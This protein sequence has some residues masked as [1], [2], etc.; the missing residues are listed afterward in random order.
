VGII[1]TGFEAIFNYAAG[2][3]SDYYA[4][5]LDAGADA[6]AVAA[7]VAAEGAGGIKLNEV[8]FR[9]AKILY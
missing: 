3:V 7:A 4:L 8:G 5:K 1:D 9:P 6:A 2:F